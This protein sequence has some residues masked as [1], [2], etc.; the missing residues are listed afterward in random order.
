MDASHQSSGRKRVFVVASTPPHLRAMLPHVELLQSSEA[1]EP[2][3]LFFSSRLLDW[4]TFGC[5]EMAYG[6][7][8][9]YG[10]RFLSK[11]Q[12]ISV[13]D[14]PPPVSPS[15][16]DGRRAWMT[17][18][19]DRWKRAARKGE[20]CAL[21]LWRTLFALGERFPLPRG[22][23]APKIDAGRVMLDL[24]RMQ[25][26]GLASPLSRAHGR[27]DRSIQRYYWERSLKMFGVEEQPDWADHILGLI[28]EQKTYYTAFR[29]LIELEKPDLIVLP[30]DTP[31]A[32]THLLV[33][34]ARKNGIPSVVFP[35]TISNHNEIAQ[36][37]P[38]FS[39]WCDAGY[40]MSRILSSTFPD[41]LLSYRGR[42]LLYPP[43]Y[44]LICEYLG[45]HYDNPWVLNTGATNVVAVDSRFMADYSSRSGIDQSKIVVTGSGANDEMWSVLRE[46][47]EYR[48]QLFRQHGKAG[49][50]AKIILIAVPPD[51]FA[52]E[53]AHLEFH[54]H[55]SLAKFMI[56][57]ALDAAGKDDLVL[58]SLHPNI[59]PDW[60]AWSRDLGAV[61]VADPIQRFVPLA[62]IFVAVASA[63]IRFAIMCGVPVVNYDVYGFEWGDYAGV[64]GVLEIKTKADY[65]MALTR[66]L[67]DPEY[68][69]SLMKVM[70]ESQ[71]FLSGV[72]GKSKSRIVELF[73]RLTDQTGQIAA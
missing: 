8:V 65:E 27:V 73:D 47:E 12:Y 2:F 70:R 67:N 24:V 31:L 20:V 19:L 29:E 55:Q 1:Y 21:V 6:A 64:S 9:F 72:D 51:L 36:G 43:P 28:D 68:Y 10:A 59:S 71:Y 46:R 58:L 33:D 3:L 41:W 60:A 17:R 26:E 42:L 15:P 62:D 53:H 14:R 16:T 69:D 61:V 39:R 13:R 56:Q 22:S 38:Y 18:V 4:N 25:W 44:L 5:A 11:E 49:T 30:E 66:M 52:R 50:E 54:D 7:Y 63:T 57:T 45:L 32:Y 35:F 23:D 34:V 40:G 37:V 48:H